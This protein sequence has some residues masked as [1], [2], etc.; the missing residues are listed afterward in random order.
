MLCYWFPVL[1]DKSAHTTDW[2]NGNKGGRLILQD[3]DSTTRVEGE[4]KRLNTLNHYKVGSHMYTGKRGGG[5]VQMPQHTQSLLGRLTPGYR[6][7]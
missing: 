7:Q 4:Y 5:G 6:K 1:Y 3:D 2:T